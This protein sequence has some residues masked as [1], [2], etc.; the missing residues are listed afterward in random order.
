[1]KHQTGD[2]PYFRKKVLG[3]LYDVPITNFSDLTMG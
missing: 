3:A 2:L 1:M